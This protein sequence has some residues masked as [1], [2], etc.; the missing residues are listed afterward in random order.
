MAT[1]K[2]KEIHAT[3]TS[4]TGLDTTFELHTVD[5]TPV[6]WVDGAWHAGV[7][8]DGTQIMVDDDD[9]RIV[10]WDADG[11]PSDVARLLAGFGSVSD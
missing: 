2:D 7:R 8:P 3:R 1:I 5:G 10:C 6:A 9:A 11:V 4:L